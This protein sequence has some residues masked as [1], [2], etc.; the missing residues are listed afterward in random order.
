MR[1]NLTDA[2]VRS[3]ESPAQ[4]QLEVWDLKTPGFGL[5]I[6]QGGRRTWTCLYRHDGRLRRLTLG[7]YPILSLADARELAR[8]RLADVQRGVDVA[9]VKQERREADSFARLAER[10]LTEWARVKKRPRSVREDERVINRELLPRWGHR[11]AG[12]IGRRDV[13]EL[14]D[15]IAAR[16]SAK[17]PDGAGVQAN[18]TLALIS[19]MYGFGVDKAIV[20]SNPAYKVPRPGAEHQRD[21]VLGEGE[22]KTLWRALDGEKPQTA[23]IFR[24]ALLTAQRRGEICGLRWDELD[25]DAGWW[26]IAAARAKNKLAH[27]VPLAGQALA[28]LREVRDRPHDAVFVFRSGSR[29]DQAIANLQKPVRRLKATSGVDFRFHDLRRTAASLMTGIGVP[30]LIVSKIL[31]HVERG[32][33]AVYDR[34]SYDGEKRAALIRWDARLHEIVTGEVAPKVVALSA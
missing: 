7:T 19:K 21:R 13:I 16:K 34:H 3:I 25:L 24:L 26:T 8:D 27:R 9:S 28:L 6:S 14:V 4:G 29:Y 30:R 12:E 31:N 11:K 10:Y 5:R 20:E 33:T 1:A 23:A 18:R 2:L 15:A 22:I 17:S 32:I